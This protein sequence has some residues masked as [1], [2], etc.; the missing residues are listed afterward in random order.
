VLA[1]RSVLVALARAEDVTLADS[2]LLAFGVEA[3]DGAIFV[4]GGRVCWAVARGMGRRL[5]EILQSFAPDDVDFDEI[6]RRCRETGRA[7]GDTLL[8]AGY[9]TPLQL[10]T[11]L[12]RHSAEALLALA[13]LAPEE[14]AWRSRGE[15]GYAAQ[16]TFRPLDVLLEAVWLWSPETQSSA[17]DVLEQ[18]AADGRWG[19]AFSIG[20]EVLPV[21]AFGSHTVQS[22]WALGRWAAQLPGATRELGSAA[23]LAIATTDTGDTV[24]TWWG[25]DLIYAI[26]C[27][28][29]R[30]IGEVIQYV[31]AG[32]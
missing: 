30:A 28:D 4:E 7:L 32:P 24:A 22:T 17:Q 26:V 23:S 19:A 13:H 29:R 31:G 12:R 5:H 16:F 18:F 10:E 14:P 27:E 1:W 20:D 25:E 21:A 11:G 3:A 2:G 6:Y 15:R 8:E 9:I